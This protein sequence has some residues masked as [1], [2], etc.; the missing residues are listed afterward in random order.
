LAGILVAGALGCEAHQDGWDPSRS[1]STRVAELDLAQGQRFEIYV[2]ESGEFGYS[3]SGKY[4]VAPVQVPEDLWRQGD[5]VQIF[6][7]LAPGRDVPAT[8]SAALR[9][10]IERARSA[11]PGPPARDDGIEQRQQALGSSDVSLIGSTEFGNCPFSFFQNAAADGGRRFCPAPGSRSWCQQS[12]LWS[13]ISV[14]DAWESHAA[15]CSDSGTAVLKAHNGN[16]NFPSDTFTIVQQNWQYIRYAG[17]NSCPFPLWFCGHVRNF[18]K[19]DVA[20]TG[21]VS[22]FGGVF[23]F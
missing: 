3:Q 2:T 9:R 20:N 7:A 13:F 6:K 22:H 10:A 4:G 14:P 12:V 21:A 19:F 1:T 16:P 17:F 15:V 18:K 8:L 5:P 23:G 11:P